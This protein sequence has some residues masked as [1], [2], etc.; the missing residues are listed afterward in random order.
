MTKDE[1]AVMAVIETMTSSFTAGDI[2]AVM[3]SYTED[4]VVMM[5]PEQPV[6]GHAPLSDAFAEFAS[7]SPVFT[8]SGHEVIVAGDTAVHFAPWSME[9]TDP[10]GN[11]VS[12]TGLSVAILKRQSDG[13]WKMVIDNPYGNRL[14]A[15]D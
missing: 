12:G 6:T 11:P 14:L 7:I 15:A 5:Y 9:G 3:Q 13:G 4:A 1:Q 10:A 8:Y 2:P